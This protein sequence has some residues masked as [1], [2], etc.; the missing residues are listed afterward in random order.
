MTFIAGAGQGKTAGCAP[1]PKQA[2]R[3]E[4]GRPVHAW[5]RER[6]RRHCP[7]DWCRSAKG[8]SFNPFNFRVYP[9]VSP[10]IK[11]PADDTAALLDFQIFKMPTIWQAGICP[12]CMAASS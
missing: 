11:T 2:D 12:P 10:E 1:G 4:R 3:R 9:R 7:A 6:L 8:A 5:R